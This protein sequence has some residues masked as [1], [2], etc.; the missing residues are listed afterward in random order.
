MHVLV[1]GSN[2]LIG[3]ALVNVLVR[4]ED[5]ITTLVR[6]DAPTVRQITRLKWD[7]GAETFVNDD[8]ANQLRRLRPM[9]KPWSL[10]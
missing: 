9:R 3:S 2:G 6:G 8:E 1:T 5:R 7:P 4:S 10:V